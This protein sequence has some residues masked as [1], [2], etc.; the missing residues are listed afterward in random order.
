VLVG[1]LLTGAGALASG[2]EMWASL[3]DARLAASM[4]RDPSAAIDIYETG[5]A[6]LPDDDPIR[7]EVSYWLARERVMQGQPERARAAL[8]EATNHPGSHDHARSFIAEL[9]RTT[10]E[11]TELPLALDFSEGTGPWIRG[12]PQGSLDDLR[13]VEADAPGGMAL[14]WQVEVTPGRDDFIAMPL[15]PDAIVPTRLQLFV[16]SAEQPTWLRILFHDTEGRRWT[17]P[18]IEVPALAWTAVDLI[19]ADLIRADAPFARESPPEGDLVMLE[20]R[21]VTAFHSE[22]RG[23][24]ELLFD[25]LLLR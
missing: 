15:S 12:W 24:N 25:D 7:G 17:S 9:D 11:V 16:W 2:P 10:L 13:T 6:F 23:P 5:L 4:D 14:A 20:L 1:L 8:L 18:V 3:Y 19:V 22:V 21:D